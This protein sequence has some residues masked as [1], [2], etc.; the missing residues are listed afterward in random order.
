MDSSTA[1]ASRREY[2]SHGR[3][4]SFRSNGFLRLTVFICTVQHS[5][6]G[7][8]KECSLPSRPDRGGYGWLALTSRAIF[9]EAIG[10]FVMAVGEWLA[11]L[12]YPGHS[13]LSQFATSFHLAVVNASPM[14]R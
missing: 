7:L 4:S 11:S 3:D 12:H 6:L 2:V 5:H 8:R 14:E 13:G 9:N 10:E 1:G